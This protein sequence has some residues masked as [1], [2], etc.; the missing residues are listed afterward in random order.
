MKPED[1]YKYLNKL[2]IKYELFEH[3]RHSTVKQ[4]KRNRKNMEG[5]HLKNLF[6][7]DKKKKFPN[8]YS[9]RSGS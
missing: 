4:S 7:R 2:D 3:E 8:C 6:L 9:R 1:L 5:F